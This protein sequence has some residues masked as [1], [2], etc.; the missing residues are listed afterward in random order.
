VIAR[1]TSQEI[2]KLREA[3]QLV[4]RILDELIGMTAPGVT[5]AEL[6]AV[7]EAR[8]REGGAEPAFKGYRGYPAC[9]CVS[10]EDEIVHGIP[11]GRVLEDGQLVSIDV[12]VRLNGYYG[13]AA[14]TAPCGEVDDTRRRLLEATEQALNNGVLAARAGARLRAVSKAVQETA[15]AAG[16]A[17]VRAFVGHGIGEAMHEEPQIPNYVTRDAGPPLEA[18]MVLA[19]E[20]MVNAGGSGVRVLDDGWTAVTQDGAPSA[21][22]EHTIA[23]T[24][25][26]AEVLSA[27][28]RRVWA[29]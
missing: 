7:A 25:G 19:L 21:H 9:V 10:V 27:S 16:F 13:D 22:F 2:D 28:P 3:N 4:G 5:T 11:G 12:G 17:V 23:I 29:R 24:G 1:R 20:P 15:E 8:I 18:G 6:D 14:V 26:A